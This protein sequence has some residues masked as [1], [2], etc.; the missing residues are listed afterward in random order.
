MF[1]FDRMDKKALFEEADEY[2]DRINR[3]RPL[4]DNEIKSLKD[5]FKIFLTYTSNAIEGNTLTETET[6]V[7][8]EDG[9]TVGGKPIKDYYEAAGHAEAYEYMW[10]IARDKNAEI[11]E[12]LIKKLHELFYYKINGDKAGEYRTERIFITGTEYVPPVPAKV[13]ELMKKFVDDMNREKNRLH[14]IEWAALLHKGLVDIHPF[15][16]G[17]GRTARLLMNLAL[18]QSGYGLAVIPPILRGDYITTLRISQTAH[19]PEPLICLIASCVIE[20]QKDYCRMLNIP[21]VNKKRGVNRG[22]GN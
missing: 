19:N 7:L 4:S 11:S 3:S 15:V 10:N 12:S 17:N 2:R 22:L 20:T 13:P 8:I 1:E 6:K 18:I 14:P 21:L 16:D 5:Y 9:L